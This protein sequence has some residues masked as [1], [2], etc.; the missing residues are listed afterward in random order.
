M[1]VE[2]TEKLVQE[3]NR[4]LLRTDRSMRK[5]DSGVKNVTQIRNRCI[6]WVW[7]LDFAMDS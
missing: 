4:F 2:S 7:E 1:G 6:R 5:W 3:V